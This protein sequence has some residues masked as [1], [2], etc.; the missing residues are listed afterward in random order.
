[1]SDELA[2]TADKVDDWLGVILS[3]FHVDG[4]EAE[5]YRRR[6][7]EHQRDFADKGTA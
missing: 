3:G 1:M 7:R 2:R 6:W 5:N 4:L